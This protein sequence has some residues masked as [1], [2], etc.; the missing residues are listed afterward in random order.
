MTP[1]IKTAATS[2]QQVRELTRELTVDELVQVSGGA[3]S[4]APK[5]DPQVYRTYTLENTMISGY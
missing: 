3:P 4:A 1:V 5:K 2:Q